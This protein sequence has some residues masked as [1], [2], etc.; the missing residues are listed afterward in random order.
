MVFSVPLPARFH[1]PAA[2]SV[3]KKS[4]KFAAKRIGHKN[5][6]KKVQINTEETH[7]L[8][9]IRNHCTCEG[10]P[11][12][13]PTVIVCR[14]I[15]LAV[16]WPTVFAPSW[17]EVCVMI[18]A[19]RDAGGFSANKGMLLLIR[20]HGR[21]S[22]SGCVKRDVFTTAGSPFEPAHRGAIFFTRSSSDENM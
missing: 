9:Y 21:I 13:P 5:N 19:Q 7:L 3:W 2:E 18:E 1:N 10:Q 12:R 20:T 15:D 22:P 11:I 14:P 16:P 4:K 6:T 8:F 17:H